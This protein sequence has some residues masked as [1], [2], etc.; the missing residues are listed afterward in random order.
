MV[1]LRARR[2]ERALEHVEAVHLGRA[3]ARAGGE[4]AYVAQVGRAA[5]Q[6]VGVE[7]QDHVA[8]REAV[9]GVDVVAEGEPRPGARRVAADRLPLVP[10]RFG[11]S[12]RSAPSWLARV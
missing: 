3:G 9:S 4:I 8:F 10:A 11:S 1:G 5:A 2:G 6:E 12:R 7:G